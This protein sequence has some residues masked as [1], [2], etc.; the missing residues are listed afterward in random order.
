MIDVFS[1]TWSSSTATSGRETDVDKVYQSGLQLLS[2][3][4]TVIRISD[5]WSDP[6]WNQIYHSVHEINYLP[7]KVRSFTFKYKTSV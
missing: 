1:P 6:L 5:L 2:S 7:I 4:V 3:V